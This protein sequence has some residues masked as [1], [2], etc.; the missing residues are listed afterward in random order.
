MP[1]LPEVETVRR[2][3]APLLAGRRI[4]DVR[5]LSP[6]VA[7]GEPAK[8]QSALSGRRIQG[9]SR[10]GKHLLVSLDRGLLDIHLRMTGKLLWNAEPG[11]HARAVIFLDQGVLVFDDVRQFGRFVL[12]DGPPGVG[13]DALDIDAPAFVRCLG[14]CRGA[15]KPLLLSQ[16]RISGLGNIY[17]DEILYRAGIHPLARSAKLS[18]RRRANLYVQMKAVLQEAIDAGGSSIS[19]YVN[20]AGQPGRFQ[21]EH[22]VYGKTGEPCPHCGTAIRR[23]VVSQR[24]THFCPACQKR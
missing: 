18:R 16:R 1:E 21:N 3:L 19:D 20:S 23:I 14:A 10:R 11:P 22:R 4:L 13:D 24:G 15:I 8:L 6:L 5:F 7:G 17:V 9:V 2:A 12:R